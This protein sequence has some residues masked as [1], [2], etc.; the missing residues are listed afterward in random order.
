MAI[1]VRFPKLGLTMREGTFLRWLKEVDET[2][3]KGEILFEV[4]SDKVVMEIEAPASGFL[5]QTAAAPGDVVPVGQVIGLIA[6]SGEKRVA[7]GGPGGRAM[8]SSTAKASNGPPGERIMASPVAR[9]MAVEAGI[10]LRDV[11]GSGPKGRITKEDVERELAEGEVKT[12][13]AHVEPTETPTRAVV[14]PPASVEAIP[15]VGVR[16]T[17]AERM[18]HSA[19]T[20]A[21]VTLTT[22]A[23]ATE[24]VQLRGS[25]KTAF[26]GTEQP[27]P[28][29]NDILIKIVA[30]ALRE[31][32]ALNARLVDDEIHRLHEVNVGLAVDVDAGLYV[33]V[34]RN[35]DSLPL[36]AIAAETRRLIERVQR[37]VFLPDDLLG[38]TFTITNLG[39]Y[40]IDAFTPIINPP[41]CAVLGVGQIALKP[42]VRGDQIVARS[43]VT[44]S[45][46]FDHRLVDG[47]PA[48]RFLQQIKR[49]V[50]NPL[51]L[52]V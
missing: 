49:L 38:G 22:E 4:E 13:P 43:V 10:D 35:A 5:V 18:A 26:E 36:G 3:Q 19:H 23:D 9:R 14:S 37:G 24:M 7:T 39:G 40:E 27:V 2:V 12:E 42:V 6:E 21:R 30:A 52:L 34:V 28:S 17:I 16:R 20:T 1:E 48:A 31:H 15:F 25:F 46:T 41:E 45:L 47:A 8:T 51:K 11:K 32:L 29:Y 33:P 50:E 44:L